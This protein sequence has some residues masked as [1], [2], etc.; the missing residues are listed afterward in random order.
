[1]DDIYG[2][3]F[4]TYG[5]KER[6]SDPMDDHYHGTHCAGTIGAIGNNGEGVTGVCWNVQIMALKFISYDSNTGWWA[7][8][9][10]DAIA[11]ID[12]AVNMG[13]KV[14]SNSW[15]GGDYN[16]A[17]LNHIEAADA[18]GVLF[19]A[20]A[21]NAG[22]NNDDDYPNFP[23]SYDCNNIIAVM[24]TDA[25]DVISQH[26]DRPYPWYWVSNYGATS[27]DLGA[28]G[29][30]ILSTFPT[31][32]TDEMASWGF[33][34]YYETISGTSMATPH[35]AGACALV[36]S[37]NSTLSHLQLKDIILNT[38][39][40]LPALDG[41]CVT[42]GRLN[43]YNALLTV[44]KNEQ[45]LS[46]V[47]DVNDGNSVLPGDEITYTIS[48]GNPVTDPNDPNYIELLTNVNIVDYLLE[49]VDYNNP[50]D[51][52]YDIWSHTYTWD[53]GTLSPGESNSVTLKVQVSELTEPLGTITNKAV[54]TSNVG[55]I[56]TTV[57]TNICCWDAGIIYVDVNAT[58]S[59]N[60]MSW[61]NAYTDL[62]SALERVRQCYASQIWVAEG[63]YK[64][65]KDPYEYDAAFELVDGV[66]IYGGFPPGGGPWRQRNPDTYET[67]M[68]G[69]LGDDI[70]V[71]N[72]VKSSN[73]TGATLDGFTIK[74][75]YNSGLYFNASALT[76]KNC[77]ITNNCPDPWSSNGGIYCTNSSF[78]NISYSEISDNNYSGGIFFS[79]CNDLTVTI[80]LI[81]GN[82]AFSGGGIGCWYSGSLTVKSCIISGNEAQTHSGG[83]IYN[84][85]SSSTITNCI[86]SGNFA[87]SG[88]GGGLLNYSCSPTIRNCVF[89]GNITTGDDGGGM[90]NNGASPTLTNCTFRKN[91]AERKGG[92]IYNHGSYP[93]IT[94][95]IFWDNT[96][97]TA[98]GNEIYNYYSTPEFSYCDIKGGLNN[99]PGCGGYASDG[100]DNID[101][102]PLFYDANDPNEYHLGAGSPC[103][104]E[105]DPYFEHEP[106]ETDIDGEDRVIDGDNNGTVIVDIGADEYYKSDAD[107]NNDDI[108][109][110]IDYAIFAAA[111]QSESGDDNYN[112]DCDLEDDNSIDYSDLALFCEDWLWQ[113]GWTK[114]FASGMGS[115]M[116]EGMNW[117]T[118]QSLTLTQETYSS[119]PAEQP[120]LT[121]SDIQEIITWTEELWR[122]EEEL[123]KYISEDEWREW[124]EWLKQQL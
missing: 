5:G 88:G 109:N 124:V 40:Q 45:L 117:T 112:E 61:E 23:S 11:S 31:Y 29:T 42:G 15:G 12:Y 3:D 97:T 16:P 119:A 68:D 106:N 104:D 4:S 103:I 67:I 87:S 26:L 7:G 69:N 13:A 18:N 93:N 36:W 75:A 99:P 115:A 84:D 110:F 121:D 47:G 6:D 92:G 21:G 58:G 102:D 55:Y 122:T 91:H 51:P 19:V 56:E 41:L 85:S 1:V 27:V 32:E 65:T 43:V 28:P 64:P 90:Y 105:G 59:N 22:A 25:D 72:V 71:Y 96:A 114:T 24:A 38:V 10:D 79:G 76:I 63:T 120:Q 108:V 113:A 94:N 44:T 62:Q 37:M 98:D 80:C 78:L 9:T 39:D 81:T 89:T 46:K 30:D 73:I 60:G 123:R 8:D 33:S 17:L 20:A 52:N 95:S 57:D 116:G 14:L 111:W 54:M 83:G 82:T 35:V 48:Y 49:E 2:Y 118:G 50:F 66:A 86:F 70:W 34:T 107:F 100:H 53:I 77:K 74:N 101:D